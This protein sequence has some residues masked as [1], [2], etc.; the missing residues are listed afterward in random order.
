MHAFVRGRYVWWGSCSAILSFL[1]S[2]LSTTV[3]PF[4]LFLLAVVLS[5]LRFTASNDLYG[6]FKLFVGASMALRNWR[7]PP[8]VNS[9]LSLLKLDYLTV[10]L[11]LLSFV[12]NST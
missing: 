11:I 8:H 5:V 12:C 9:Y 1:H 2:V 3:S 6:V 7:L 4:V 10:L